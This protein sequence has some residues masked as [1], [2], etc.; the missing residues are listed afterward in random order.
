VRITLV[1]NASSLL[2]MIYI[3]VHVCV[4]VCVCVCLSGVRKCMTLPALMTKGTGSEEEISEWDEGQ[5]VV[6][7]T[8]G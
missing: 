4:C 6:S 2:D 7:Y 3:Y 1:P 8:D 5:C